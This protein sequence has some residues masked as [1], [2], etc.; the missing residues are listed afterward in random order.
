MEEEGNQCAIIRLTG[1]SER[2]PGCDFRGY[3]SVCGSA[4]GALAVESVPV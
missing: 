2:S 4:G 1:E 3:F